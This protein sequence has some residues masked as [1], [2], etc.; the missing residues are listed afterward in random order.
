[1]TT[2]AVAASGCGRGAGRDPPPPPPPQLPP[3]PAAPAPT[4]TRTPGPSRAHSAHAH[5]FL[6]LPCS[7]SS[8]QLVAS[9]RAHAR[10]PPRSAPA[11][12]PPGCLRGNPW[13]ACARA[14]SWGLPPPFLRRPI[15][16]GEGRGAPATRWRRP[17][18]F[19]HSPSDFA[20]LSLCC[21]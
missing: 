2:A 19:K 13:S 9:E 21:E 15:R 1:M 16:S 14:L 11:P 20:K 8:P 3:P 10:R 12:W 17:S 5:P 6:E 18:R 7:P 4:R